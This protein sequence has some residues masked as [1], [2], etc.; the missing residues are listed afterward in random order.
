MEFTNRAKDCVLVSPDAGSNKKTAEIAKYFNHENFVRADK[1]RNLETGEIK[2]TIV[3][4][5][6]FSGRDVC[7]I[8]D[9]ADGARS[10]TELAKVC[11]KKNCG[12]FVLY[13]THGIFSKGMKILLDNGIDEIWTTNSFE[14]VVVRYAEEC[15]KTTEYPMRVFNVNN[16]I[17][18]REIIGYER[19]TGNMVKN[20]YAPCG[21]L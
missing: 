3:Y 12:K 1:L 6:D 20:I 9:L 8:D 2:E 19:I 11:K 13:V 5:D 21:S 7:V 16:F 4:C 10:F 15:Q 18:Q 14:S 17:V